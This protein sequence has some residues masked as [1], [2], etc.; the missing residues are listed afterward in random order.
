M[1]KYFIFDFDSTFVTVETLELLAGIV[2]EHNPEK[3]KVLQQIKDITNLGMEGKITFQESLKKR[4]ALFKPTKAAIEQVSSSLSHYVTPSIKRNKQFFNQYKEQIYVISGGFREY[5]V[6]LLQDFGINEKNI[7]ANSFIFDKKGNF[8]GI[9]ETNPLSKK[10]GKVKAVQSLGLKGKIYIIGDGYTDYEIKKEGIAHKFYAFVE[11]INRTEVSRLADKV[12]NNLDELLYTLKLPRAFSF[13]K[14]K[15]KVL[16]LENIHELGLS[17]FKKEG[18]QVTSM[19]KAL[20]EQELIGAIKEVSILGIRSK[21]QITSA[22]LEKASHLHTIGAYCIGTNQINLQE[23]ALKGI[24]VFNAPYS[25]T[26][27]VVEL[28]I[29]EIIMLSRK[30]FDKSSKLHQGIWD[31]SAAGC[32]EIRGKKL[33][34]IGYGNIGSQLSV[35][36]ENL[37]MEVY[38]YDISDKLALGNARKMNS[39]PELLQIADVVTVHVDGRKS[40][41]NLIGEDEFSLMKP[42]TIFLNAS[43]G[44]IVDIPALAMAIRQ[45]RITGA[46]IDVFPHE[47]HDNKEILKNDLQNMQNVILTP[48]IGGST[49]EAQ[50]NIADYVSHKIIQYINTGSTLMSVNFPQIQLSVATNVHRLIHI[51]E[52]KPGVLAHINNILA[53]FN[54][55]IEGQYL[56]TNEHIGYVITDIDMSYSSKLIKALMKVP[57]TI[58]LRVLF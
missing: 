44:F 25:N 40:N 38:F 45:K 11:N 14:S 22:V 27:S 46:A 18:Y 1:T 34:I 33:G 54:S 50:R 24:T 57:S 6:H 4:L 51:H 31:K 43:R 56:G 17:I 36:A 20:S 52:N 55:N 28:I 29:G 23:A 39:L 32:Y 13:P 9:D 15:I 21:T 19:K 53:D 41:Q 30:V 35:L 5:M 42:G 7:I 3:D 8:N 47:P 10:G 37:G 12:I 48:H 58:K 26:R 49:E 2:L 16:L